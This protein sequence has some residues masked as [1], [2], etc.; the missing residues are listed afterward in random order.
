MSISWPSE[1]V[2]N[3]G[4]LEFA[5]AAVTLVVG[6]L[7]L[8][9]AG[10]SYLAP[11]SSRW[12]QLGAGLASLICCGYAL[13]RIIRRREYPWIIAFAAVALP[14]YEPSQAPYDLADRVIFGVRDLAL[15]AMAGVF[16][17]RAVRTEDELEHRVQLE[18]LAW[19]Y[20]VVLL[21]LIGYALAED[22]LPPLRGVWVA[23][24]MLGIWAVAWAY[25]SL[26]YQ[27]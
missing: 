14:F 20:P 9:H 12:M 17:V 25:A 18:G 24:A 22:V 8:R 5:L 13:F 10:L 1:R 11:A 6:V 3:A 23:S 26:R 7:T 15:L 4:L 27:R 19:S 2:S 16:L 21:G